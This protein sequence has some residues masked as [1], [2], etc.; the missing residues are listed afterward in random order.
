MIQSWRQPLFRFGT[1][2]ILFAAYGLAIWLE[3]ANRAGYIKL[4]QYLDGE[5]NFPPFA[6]LHAILFAGVCWRHGANVYLPS[7]CMNGG[8]F[9]YAPLLLRAAYSGIGPGETRNIGLII[10][11]VFILALAILPA[12]LNLAEFLFRTAAAVSATTAY[13]LERANFDIIVFLL[14]LA[15][16]LC[17]RHGRPARAGAYAIFLLATA[18]K[19][20]P[21]FLLAMIVRERRPAAVALFA[22]AAIL[23]AADLIYF[24]TET[25]GAI[26]I[27][28]RIDPFKESFGAMD[29]PI[30]L[31]LLFSAPDSF[32]GRAL[33]YYINPY[34]PYGP[35]LITIIAVKLAAVLA[36]CLAASLSAGR[37][38]AATAAPDQ[39]VLPFFTAGAI[40]IAGCFFGAE[41][42]GYRAIFL[43]LTMPCLCRMLEASSGAARAGLRLLLSAIVLLLWQA[44]LYHSGLWLMQT[45]FG[46]GLYVFYGIGFWA[47]KEF[48]WWWVVVQLLAI[49]LVIFKSGAIAQKPR[50]PPQ[51]AS[52][53][54]LSDW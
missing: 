45:L 54:T 26:H 25:A 19:F 18:L 30:G 1:S 44:A 53:Q 24:H 38:R 5:P 9:N 51:A 21:V 46:T 7:A 27:I 20:Y 34:H 15:G 4:L 16:T 47:A 17:L 33:L 52:A 41:N 10:E 12:P 2:I 43:L 23:L 6:D 37:Y 11:A 13:L 22:L 49:L 48:L 31:S 29:I 50:Q 28:P 36:G 3:Q 35:E 14:V 32:A 39:A 40:L 8:V 42:A